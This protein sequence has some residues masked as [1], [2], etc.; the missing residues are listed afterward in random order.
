MAESHSEQ[1]QAKHGGRNSL[2]RTGQ[3]ARVVWSSAWNKS[4]GQACGEASSRRTEPSTSPMRERIRRAERASPPGG[5]IGSRRGV[6]PGSGTENKRSATS[7]RQQR[8]REQE[9]V[10]PGGGEESR[11]SATSCNGA[12]QGEERLP[13]ATQGAEKARPPGGGGRTSTWPA[14]AGSRQ[15]RGRR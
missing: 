3:D 1:S 11:R 4:G 5:S 8:R 13:A 9:G 2:A 7:L 10:P 12:A 14:A 6:P 15:A